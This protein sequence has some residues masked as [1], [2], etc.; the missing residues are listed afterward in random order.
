MAD[1]I[2]LNHDSLGEFII[3]RTED[4]TTEVH[5]RL[6]D[7]SVWMTQTE[8]AELFGVTIATVSIHLKNIYA[9]TELTSER[10]IRKF[11]RVRS[12]GDRDIKRE[13]NH[14][15]LDAIMAV[16]YRVR[17]PRGIQFRRWATDV[18][19]DYLVKGF[20]LNDEKLKDPRGKDYFDELLARIRDIRSSEARLYLELRD[21]VALADDYDKRSPA[22]HKIFA[23][24]QDRLHY[25]ITG[26]TASE[27]IATRCD[28][29]ADNLGLTT[30]KGKVVRKADVTTAKNYLTKQE[31][32]HL[33]L[34]VS[35]FLDYAKLR[36]E[37]RQVIHMTDWIEQTNRF[38]EFNEY[39]PLTDR[40]RITRKEANRLAGARY[41]LYDGRRQEQRNEEFDRELIPQLQE[42]E[43]R[44]L[45]DRARLAP[46]TK[47]ENP[48]AP[49]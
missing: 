22:T 44:I 16:G 34:L 39:E 33:N 41:A 28:P 36:A 7:K 31:L 25:A 32:E 10:T 12:E 8:I 23:S 3:Y 26:L 42:I 20:V 1:G 17:G 9:D 38:I 45:A 6:I 43:R 24:I 21:V 40:G 37:R 46:R 30:F 18:L 47:D 27:I 49:K 19:T 48:G 4:D 13:V 35:Q 29:A 14:Y 15:N 5:L 11:Q 2:E